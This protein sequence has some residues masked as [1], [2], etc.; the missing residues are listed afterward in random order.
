MA[1]MG[2]LDE[3]AAGLCCLLDTLYESRL[4]LLVLAGQHL[5]PPRFSGMLYA[6]CQLAIWCIST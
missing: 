5:L 2:A 6:W 4:F 1:L 3:G